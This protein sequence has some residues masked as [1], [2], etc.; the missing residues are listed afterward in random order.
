MLRK[1][2]IFHSV[3][4]AV[5]IWSEVISAEYDIFARIETIRKNNFITL[6]FDVNPL[7]NTY[8][9]IEN[10][11]II[12]KIR[13]INVKDYSDTNKISYRATAEYEIHEGQKDILK[14]GSVVG[15]RKI[16]KEREQDYVDKA[17]K[18]KVKYKNEIISQIDNR[19]MKL[20]PDGKF[21]FGFDHGD[22]DEAP[23]ILVDLDAFYIDKY[24]VTN[25]NYYDFAER[26]GSNYPLSWNK[27]MYNMEEAEMPVLVSYEEALA[28]CRWAGKRLPTE[29]E[30]EK[31]SRGTGIDSVKKQDETYIIIR[32]PVTYPWGDKFDAERSNSLEFWENSNIGKE[33][34]NKYNKGLLPVTFFEGAG[35]S[36]FGIV[37]MA[38]NASEWTSSWYGAYP[39][40]RYKD[41]KF[42]NQVK[43]IRGGSWY[44]P[45]YKVRC[46]NREIG[47][48]PN[49]YSDNIAGFRCVKNTA[50]TDS[51][52]N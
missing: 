11:D 29:E 27:K 2:F 19:V 7:E 42:G 32:K 39:G 18:V 31:A 47:G 15:L 21:V 10:D 30:W 16:V 49:L 46:S 50:L 28:Y 17:Y 3:L 36:V 1:N 51:P 40:S 24:E 8:F 9:I 48:L 45:K 37:N 38:G 13:I 23:E 52:E 25:R 6:I 26:T 4:L 5:L 35:D 20:I 22:K 12:G 34:K 41:K 43:V 44:S 14:A 33:I